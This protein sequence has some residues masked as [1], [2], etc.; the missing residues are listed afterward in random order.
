MSTS[1]LVPIENQLIHYGYPICLILGTIGNFL[2]VILFSR[3]RDN[4]CSIY[5]LTSA[6]M[7]DLYLTF[8][9]FVEIFPFYYVDETPRAFALCKIRFYISNV[10]GQ[11]AKTM[12]VLACIDRFLIT[13]NRANFRALSTPK[14]A[15]GLILISILFWPLFASHIA[16]MTTII[17]KKC[18]T[19][20]I[21]STIYTIYSIIFVG[22]IPP[23]LLG[24]FGYFTYRHMKYIHVRIQPIV[25]H[26]VNYIPI[27]RRDRELLT[28][29]ISEVFVYILTTTFYPLI[30]LEM[31]ISRYILSNK[32]VQYSQIEHFLFTI[33]FL[34]LFVNNAVPFYIYFLSSKSFR[35]DLK[36]LLI[37][38]YRKLTNQSPITIVCRTDHTLMIRRHTHI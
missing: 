14:R 20:N 5:L 26:K 12:I 30:L 38:Y 9:S 13:D 21:Y 7:N 11:L 2:I 35:R 36:E 27:Q 23:I 31:M 37:N 22:L 17:N 32:S 19:F 28:I 24:I 15:K 4:A 33:S 25:I 10:L 34:L 29:V 16:I 3:R 8:N 6:I 1:I 18:G